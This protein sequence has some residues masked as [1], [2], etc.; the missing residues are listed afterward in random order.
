MNLNGM[1]NLLKNI[2]AN[3]ISGWH[4]WSNWR[5]IWI[6]CAIDELKLSPLGSCF[7][8][9]KMSL[10]ISKCLD[11]HHFMVILC[12]T[13]KEGSLFDM[14]LIRSESCRIKRQVMGMLKNVHENFGKKNTVN[15]TIKKSQPEEKA[16]KQIH[17]KFHL[18]NVN[19][20]RFISYSW[21]GRVG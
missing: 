6:C 5:S 16:A 3:S 17:D 9:M 4:R 10:R 18:S 7:L 21:H 14:F 20:K 2:L 8:L 19:R 15:R 12:H 11:R 13:Q 1:A